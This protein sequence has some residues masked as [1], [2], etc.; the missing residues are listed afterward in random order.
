MPRKKTKPTGRKSENKKTGKKTTGEKDTIGEDRIHMPKG[1]IKTKKDEQR[2]REAKA[3]AK[4]KGLI[5]ER[6]YRYAIAIVKRRKFYAQR[7][8]RR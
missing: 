4:K 3:Q 6:L 8:R 7:K 2:W 5:G 1:L